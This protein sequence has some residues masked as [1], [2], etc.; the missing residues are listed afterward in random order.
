MSDDR[1]D[2]RGFLRVGGL[3]GAAALAAAC[4]PA[5]APGTGTGSPAGSAPAAKAQ[6]EQEWDQLVVAAKREGKL[7]VNTIFS[8]GS[9]RKMFEAFEGAF[10]GI[11]TE[12]TT[13]A[14]Q[15]LFVPKVLLEQ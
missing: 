11:T 5:A 1:L 15:S 2:R 14:S 6:W 12:Q 7:V 13:F 4:A 10:P 9:P 8:Q 3:T